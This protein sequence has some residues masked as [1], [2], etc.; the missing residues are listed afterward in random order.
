MVIPPTS[1]KSRGYIDDLRVAK[2]LAIS[3][4]EVVFASNEESNRKSHKG[5]NTAATL[6]RRI[7]GNFN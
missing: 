6:M 3:D 5:V 7:C 1:D 2:N 4:R